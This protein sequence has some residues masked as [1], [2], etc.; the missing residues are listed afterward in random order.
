L[1]LLLRLWQQLLQQLLA[2]ASAK[3]CALLRRRQMLGNSLPQDI[4]AGQ[5]Q[6]TAVQHA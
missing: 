2:Y 6:T 4:A 1:Q 5:Q 3:R